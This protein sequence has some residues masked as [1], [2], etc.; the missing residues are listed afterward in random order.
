MSNSGDKQWAQLSGYC[1]GFWWAA[2]QR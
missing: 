2:R 1:Q